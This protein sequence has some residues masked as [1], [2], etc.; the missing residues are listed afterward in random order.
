MS[1]HLQFTPFPDK[2]KKQEVSLVPCPQTP[3]LK[4]P[5]SGSPRASR[6]SGPLVPQQHRH[7]S[8]FG[9]FVEKKATLI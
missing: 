4:P 7:N 1:L 5:I 2:Y 9:V 3:L 8:P 6:A